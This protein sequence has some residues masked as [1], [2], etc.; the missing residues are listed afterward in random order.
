MPRPIPHV[1]TP[2]VPLVLPPLLAL[3]ALFAGCGEEISHDLPLDRT[4]ARAAEAVLGLDFT[5]AERDLLLPDL[6]DQRAA[7][8]ALRA[9]QLPNDAP[10]ALRFDPWLLAP[11]VFAA[12]RFSRRRKAA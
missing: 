8:L 4:R 5:G 1:A 10:P 12:G 2:L 11:A 9:H 6:L 7:Y 3:L